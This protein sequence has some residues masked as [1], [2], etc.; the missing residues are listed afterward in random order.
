MVRRGWDRGRRCPGTGCA[1]LASRTASRA[2]LMLESCR[3][4]VFGDRS[5][6][7][8]CH[9]GVP[10]TRSGPRK[11]P[12]RSSRTRQTR[13]DSH[14]SSG[15]PWQH[16][17]GAGGQ[18]RLGRALGALCPSRADREPAD[19]GGSSQGSKQER[20]W[21]RWPRVP[22]GGGRGT[23][24]ASPCQTLPGTARRGK[25]SDPECATSHSRAR[26]ACTNHVC[27]RSTCTHS[28]SMQ[29]D[30]APPHT[31]RRHTQP[32]QA[33]PGLPQPP[34]GTRGAAVAQGRGAPHH[35]VGYTPALSPRDRALGPPHAEPW[36]Q[37]H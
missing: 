13:D 24:R 33:Q 28:T 5:S 12:A 15:S 26:S 37:H 35:A 9:P 31:R 36:C 7:W 18:Q 21:Q 4:L 6:S 1:A 29:P 34:R 3:D 10:T 27:T 11:L 32:G 2:P 23:R 25:R 17:D 8:P 14:S 22:T 19:G 16:Q 20:W 30:Q